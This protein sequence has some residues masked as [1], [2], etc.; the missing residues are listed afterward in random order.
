MNDEV[1]IRSIIIIMCC[2][3]V[4]CGAVHAYERERS[5]TGE[6]LQ[7]EVPLS[8]RQ[9]HAINCRRHLVLLHFGV[10]TICMQSAYVYEMFH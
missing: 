4:R 3:C 10:K 7:P 8:H 5:Q 6:R 9:E 2:V 1:T